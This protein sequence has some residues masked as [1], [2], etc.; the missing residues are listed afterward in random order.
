MIVTPKTI[1]TTK[2][3]R[4]PSIIKTIRL[5]NGPNN[6]WWLQGND[7]YSIIHDDTHYIY[8]FLTRAPAHNCMDFLKKY[9]PKGD[10]Y[11]DEE[12]LHL[13]KK[14]CCLNN[15]GLIGI[16]DFSY[17]IDT[18][19]TKFTL[20]VYKL[21]ITGIDLLEDQKITNEEFIDNLNFLLDF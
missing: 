18:C 6:S 17:T 10:F 14:R 12:P 19:D 4:Q 15:V 11:I 9:Y 5:N 20:P 3:V 2:K 1:F 13:M 7:Y 21:D 16:T 8:T